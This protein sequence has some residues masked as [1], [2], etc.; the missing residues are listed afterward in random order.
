MDYDALIIMAL[1]ATFWIGVF[2][3][4]ARMN[5]FHWIITASVLIVVPS[6]I[7]IGAVLGAALW[8]AYV[9]AP[10]WGAAGGLL[11]AL[12][13]LTREWLIHRRLLAPASPHRTTAPRS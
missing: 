8:P 11:A 1:A 10:A 3:L 2:R 7:L 6:A 5:L 13:A 4:V 9:H 12:A